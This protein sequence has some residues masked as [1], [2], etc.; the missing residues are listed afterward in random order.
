MSGENNPDL[1]Y[2][3]DQLARG[4]HE[5]KTI[6]QNIQTDINTTSKTLEI[7][8][9]TLKAQNEASF[10]GIRT[11]MQLIR[12]NEIQPLKASIE[13]VHRLVKGDDHGQNSLLSRIQSLEYK[14][15]TREEDIKELK[16][17]KQSEKKN[18]VVLKAEDRRGKWLLIGAAITAVSSLG[19]TILNLIFK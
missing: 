8:V 19:I 6:V 3:A 18:G 10:G 9:E 5:T 4:L 1:K 11:E 13:S 7:K 14:D 12:A 2:V 17:E 15:K 16:D